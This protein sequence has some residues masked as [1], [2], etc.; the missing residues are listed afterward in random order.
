MN[1][2]IREGLIDYNSFN[3]QIS[4]HKTDIIK[5]LLISKNISHI[6]KKELLIQR[7]Y[8]NRML[9][10]DIIE[11]ITT[12]DI[13]KEYHGLKEKWDI[14]VGNKKLYTIFSELLTKQFV[15]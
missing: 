8:K 11:F 3:N 13:Y 6:F 4:R 15:V 14:I 12:G 7:L 9:Y 1:I 2:D 5:K 10:N